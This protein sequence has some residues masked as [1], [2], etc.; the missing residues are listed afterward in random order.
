MLLLILVC[1]AFVMHITNSAFEYESPALLSC[2]IYMYTSIH[3]KDRVR[4][5]LNE[6][7]YMTV[8]SHVC[9]YD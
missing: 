4:K 9:T 7:L 5:I 6:V 2:M 3:S 1:F 8:A